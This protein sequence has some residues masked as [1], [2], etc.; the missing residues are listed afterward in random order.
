MTILEFDDLTYFP[1]LVKDWLLTNNMFPDFKNYIFFFSRLAARKQ[2]LEEILHDMEARIE[3]EEEKTLKMNEERK[4]LH[5]HIQDLE[6]QL[7]EEEAARQ[8]MQIEKVQAEA[9]IK[10]YEE[11]L[12]V[13]ED[14]NQKSSKEK[15][16]MEERL[17]DVMA[18]LAEEEEKAKHLAKL[19]V[20]TH[21]VEKWKIL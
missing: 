11:E 16:M 15:K 4:K 6:E 12:A 7:E 17:G 14:S 5:L 19:K 20:R 9:K 2:E 18:T 13:V 3:E 1:I 21:S 10:K 8:K